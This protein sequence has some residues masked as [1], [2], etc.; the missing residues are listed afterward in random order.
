MIAHSVLCKLS[1]F[2]SFYSKHTIRVFWLRWKAVIK[3]DSLSSRFIE[4]LCQVQKK[5]QYYNIR[6]AFFRLKSWSKLAK[7]RASSLLHIVTSSFRRCRGSA[8]RQAL[9]KWNK[10]VNL[11]L[12]LNAAKQDMITAQAAIDILQNIPSSLFSDSSHQGVGDTAKELLIRS[13]ESI[14]SL[15]PNMVVIDVRYWDVAANKM[16]S[17]RECISSSNQSGTGMENET[18]TSTATAINRPPPLTRQTD[19]LS[20]QTSFRSPQSMIAG[21]SAALVSPDTSVYSLKYK[22]VGIGGVR[23][24][25]L[26]ARHTGLPAP[27]PFTSTA[28]SPVSWSKSFTPKP[29]PYIMMSSSPLSQPSPSRA[30]VGFVPFKV[31]PLMHEI[32]LVDAIKAVELREVIIRSVDVGPL[33]GHMRNANDFVGVISVTSVYA[34]GPVEVGLITIPLF[35]RDEAIGVLQLLVNTTA[36]M[37]I[38]DSNNLALLTELL[39]SKPSMQL[40]R[41]SEDQSPLRNTMTALAMDCISL[42]PTVI[43]AFGALVALLTNIIYDQLVVAQPLYEDMK[44]STVDAIIQTIQDIAL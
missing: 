5:A 39:S 35:H 43:P 36:E 23:E 32:L 12:A 28:S 25:P 34:S 37:V 17:C 4:R 27:Y 11:S 3:L 33:S 31:N 24:S 40:P 42:P 29:S 21:S 8:L 10:V 1:P 6:T 44:V 41:A 14:S 20:L 13:S 38:R 26:G 18:S 7:D 9:S 2:F 19:A 22:S 15:A 30:N 16:M